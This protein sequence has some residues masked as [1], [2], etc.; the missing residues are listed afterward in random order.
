MGAATAEDKD[1]LDADILLVTDA[2]D[3]LTREIEAARKLETEARDLLTADCEDKTLARDDATLADTCDVVRIC[4]Q[5]GLEN[6][7]HNG[8][9]RSDR[10]LGS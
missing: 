6:L 3:A 8:S 9:R 7:A 1:A 2:L 5:L 10:V 4:V